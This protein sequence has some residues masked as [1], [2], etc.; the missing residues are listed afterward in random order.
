[1]YVHVIFMFSIFNKFARISN[2]T[3]YL[4]IMGYV[5]KSDYNLFWIKPV[6]WQNLEQMKCCEYFSDPVHKLTHPSQRSQEVKAHQQ[7]TT[8]FIE[9]LHLCTHIHPLFLHIHT[10]KLSG[11]VCA[12]NSQKEDSLH[13]KVNLFHS[14]SANSQ[15]ALPAK[16]LQVCKRHW[17]SLFIEG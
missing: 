2:L 3:F 12:I 14:L 15:V 13:R 16:L 9:Y 5:V 8:T 17:P 1:M 11:L 6:T 4:V 7:M 10:E